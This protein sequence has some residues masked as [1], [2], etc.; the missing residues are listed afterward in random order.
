MQSAQMSGDAQKQKS[1]KDSPKDPYLKALEVARKPFEAA[2]TECHSAWKKSLG[3]AKPS[4][5]GA[6]KDPYLKAFEAAQKASRSVFEKGLSEARAEYER[7][8][9]DPYLKAFQVSQDF[10]RDIWR[11]GMGD[12]RPS[13]ELHDCATLVDILG[14]A[15]FSQI[16]K[17][18]V[19]GLEDPHLENVRKKLPLLQNGEIEPDGLGV[20]W[21]QAAFFRKIQVIGRI[22]H[23]YQD[24]RQVH[25]RIEVEDNGFTE[26][27]KKVLQQK[28]LGFEI[29]ITP[30]AKG[31]C[32]Q[33]TLLYDVRWAER[34]LQDVIEALAC[35]RRLPAAVLARNES[36]KLHPECR[37]PT[38]AP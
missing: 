15:R 2:Q 29:N 31:S 37:D 8:S 20:S 26:Q 33:T 21:E 6:S 19:I 32:S 38:I 7:F 9:K 30:N 11:K 13:S 28:V 14:Q 16:E 27:F 4:S 22:R 5:E 24:K 34:A 36:I 25:L 23:L 1:A 35:W 12:A 17:I 10:C 18:V 3:E